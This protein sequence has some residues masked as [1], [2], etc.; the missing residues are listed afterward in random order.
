MKK[1]EIED[2]YL[3]AL[4]EYKGIR[5]FYTLTSQTYDLALASVKS[6]KIVPKKYEIPKD[7]DKSKISFTPADSEIEGLVLVRGWLTLEDYSALSGLSV[8][9]IREKEEN[10]ELTAI[11]ELDGKKVIFWPPEEHGGEN[12]MPV[13]SEREYAIK[14]KRT[15]RITVDIGDN[16]EDM[17]SYLG[18]VDSLEKNTS[19]AKSVLNRETFLLFWTTFEQYVKSLTFTLFNLFPEQVLKNKKYGKNQLSYIDIFDA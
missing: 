9:E 18:P 11:G 17:I 2:V 8:D 1:S 19:E 3:N 10:G 12:L 5:D 13:N 6:N 14:Y 4:N 15:G 7:L 16:V